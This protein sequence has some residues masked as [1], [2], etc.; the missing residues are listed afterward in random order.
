MRRSIF[1]PERYGVGHQSRYFDDLD[2]AGA[3]FCSGH[4]HPGADLKEST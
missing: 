3:F 2:D 4:E 1:E